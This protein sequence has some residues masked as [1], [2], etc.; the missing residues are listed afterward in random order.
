MSPLWTVGG[1][2]GFLFLEQRAAGRDNTNDRWTGRIR[3]LLLLVFLEEYLSQSCSGL[4]CWDCLYLHMQRILLFWA[5]RWQD[6]AIN[7][8][9][10]SRRATDDPC[11]TRH[12]GGC[13]G[14]LVS[15]FFFFLL[16]SKGASFLNLICQNNINI[17]QIP[18]DQKC[19]V[20]STFTKRLLDD[21]DSWW[22]MSRASPS[23]KF[24]RQR[25]LILHGQQ[26]FH[27][28]KIRLTINLITICLLNPMV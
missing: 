22:I 4:L 24:T 23:V 6:R 7:H 17:Q 10:Y 8:P 11:R 16:N 5:H 12:H 19:L 1:R 25:T 18:V 21:N 14:V 15:G 20:V 3:L 27:C 2:C 26:I 13:A 28:A 9:Q